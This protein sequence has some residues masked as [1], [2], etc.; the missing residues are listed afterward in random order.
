MTAI[1]E[2]GRKR[3]EKETSSDIVASKH[4]DHFAIAIQL[5]EQPFFHILVRHGEHQHR[6]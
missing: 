2:V 4:A 5:D 6:Y 1:I 3:R